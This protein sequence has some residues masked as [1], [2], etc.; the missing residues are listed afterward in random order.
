MHA[1]LIE[2]Y[3]LYVYRSAW[4]LQNIPGIALFLRNKEQCYHLSYIFFKIVPF[5]KHTILSATVKCWKQSSKPFYGSLF[6][7]SFAFLMMAVAEKSAIPSVL[8]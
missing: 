7:F 5:L 8:I 4:K 2:T 6:G 3:R 1:G